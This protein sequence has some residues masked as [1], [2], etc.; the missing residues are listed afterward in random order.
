MSVKLFQ[1]LDQGRVTQRK[2]EHFSYRQ[3]PLGDS[4]LIPV[5]QQMIVDQ[6]IEID[7]SLLVD[8][9]LFIEDFKEVVIPPPPVFTQVDQ[10]SYKLINAGET[11]T[12]PSDQEMFLADRVDIDGILIVDGHLAVGEGVPPVD[13]VVLPADNFSYT[14]VQLAQVIN[15]PVRQQ[16][17]VDGMATVD[18][19]L[20]IDGEL[21]FLSTPPEV[22][23]EFL[24]WYEIPAGKVIQI[25]QYREYFLSEYLL[26]DGEL[27]I[28]TGGRLAIGA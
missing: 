23:D 7:G 22:E 2:G 21:S 18:G 9:E 27:Q 17:V 14:E 6:S 8:G 20:E 3:I 24:P 26:L 4:A 12:I 19:V 25:K 10:F 13:P 1:E 16:M 11:V 5:E 28:E 15:I